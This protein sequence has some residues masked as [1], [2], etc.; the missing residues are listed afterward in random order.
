MQ[1]GLDGRLQGLVLGSLRAGRAKKR[2]ICLLGGADCGK[3]FLL[4]GL[5]EVF[6]VYERP[7]SGSYQ[8]GDL[9]GKE[10]VLLNDFT[11]GDVARAGMSWP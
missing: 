2:T 9:A 3:T 1:N 6:H 5:S 10:L 7:D 8:L 11:Y 4:R